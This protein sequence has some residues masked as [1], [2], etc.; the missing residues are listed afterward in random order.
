MRG[1]EG[2]G[3][4]RRSGFEPSLKQRNRS[5]P[6]SLMP[7]WIIPTHSR[8]RFPL[9]CPCCPARSPCTSWSLS[10]A[11]FSLFLASCSCRSGLCLSS[12][13]LA[14]TSRNVAK[15][16]RG[17][18]AEVNLV[19]ASCTSLVLSSVFARHSSDPACFRST[20]TAETRFGSFCI[21]SFSTWSA[22]SPIRLPCRRRLSWPVAHASSSPEH[23]HCY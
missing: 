6:P 18:A 4:S 10:R 3:V 11:P 23:V 13:M 1:R 16:F 7:T 17:A 15:V 9:R 12:H 21:T 14:S 2:E 19:R 8:S 20:L 22:H 5:H